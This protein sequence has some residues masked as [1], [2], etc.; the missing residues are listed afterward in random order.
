MPKFSF[1]LQ[2]VLEYRE[3]EE[4]WAKDAYLAAQR[5]RNDKLGEIKKLISH[6]SSVV[7]L[8][9]NSIDSRL[10]L[11]RVLE[12]I[13]DEER[14]HRLAL[15]ILE[16]EELTAE[17]E[18]TVKRQAVKAIEKLRENALET[19]KLDEERREQADLDE[20]TTM[21]RVA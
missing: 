9:A 16:N 2:K 13:D 12:R 4:G 19:W 7:S 3:M 5:E 10:H 6:R 17:A 18:W 21:R 15:A 1:R 14:H 8:P 11:E 20:W